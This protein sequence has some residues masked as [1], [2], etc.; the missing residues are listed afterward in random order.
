MKTSRLS[1]RHAFTLLEVL[2][3][4]TISGFVMAGIMTLFYYTL[5]NNYVGEQRLLANNDV[6]FFTEKMISNA[7]ASNVMRL[8][9]SFYIYNSGPANNVFPFTGTLGGTTTPYWTDT[10][11]DINDEVPLGQTGDFLVLVSYFGSKAATDPFL[12]YVSNSNPGNIISNVGLPVSRLILYWVAPNTA[13]P[14]ENAMY[15]FDS[16]LT[17]GV[18]PWNGVNLAAQG[19]YLSTTS[20]LEALLPNNTATNATT[21]YQG[22]IYNGAN[23]AQIVLNDVRGLSADGSGLNF[24]NYT[25]T[26]YTSVLMKSLILHG[27][28]AKRV[29]DTYDFTITPGG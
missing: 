4:L 29:T 5:E 14:G 18:L 12:N 22:T 8:Y 16:N 7:R 21:Y 19:T 26:A 11:L 24:T 17:N 20:A 13:F 23:W 15:M 3:A 2:I 1:F 9:K 10:P 6:R 25:T 28:A 27:N